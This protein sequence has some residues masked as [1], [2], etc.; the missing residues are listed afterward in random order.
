MSITETIAGQN[1]AHTVCQGK[2]IRKEIVVMKRESASLAVFLV[3][4]ASIVTENAENNATGR[5][6]KET[7]VYVRLDVLRDTQDLDVQKVSQQNNLKYYVR[8]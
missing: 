1:V 3:G 4:L 7:A 5:L 8:E 6:A 2:Y